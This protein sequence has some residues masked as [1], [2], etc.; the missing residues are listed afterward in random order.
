MKFTHVPGKNA[1]HRVAL[2]ALSTCGWCRKTKELLDANQIQ[3]EY[4]YVDQCQG[5]E[6]TEASNKV[7]E[8]NPRGS[9]PTIKIDTEV[10]TGFDE[11]RL[12][13]LLEI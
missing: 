12:R 13:E 3:Y 7:R 10:V 4:I 2:Y 5:D 8:L 11:D 1:K 9:F 6:R